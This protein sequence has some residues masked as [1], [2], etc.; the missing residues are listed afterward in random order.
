MK[1]LLA[2]ILAVAMMLSLTACGGPA[3]DPA[4]ESISEPE[5]A[6]EPAPEPAPEPVSEPEPEAEPVIGTVT[7]VSASM[8]MLQLEDGTELVLNIKG[9]EGLEV[10]VGDTVIAEHLDTAA[11]SVKVIV[12]D[13]DLAPEPVT[14]EPAQTAPEAASQAP[15]IKADRTYT[16]VVTGFSQ[17]TDSTVFTLEDGS[18]L[19]FANAESI[20]QGLNGRKFQIGDKVIFGETGT[21]FRAQVTSITLTNAGSGSTSDN[22]SSGGSSKAD[23]PPANAGDVYEAIDLINAEREKVGLEKLGIDS[24][25]MEMAAVRAE[26]LVTKYEHTRPDGRGYISIL[27]DFGWDSKKYYSAENINRSAA[28]AATTV[29]SWMNSAGHKA[30]ILNENVTR[31]GVGYCYGSSSERKNHWVMLVTS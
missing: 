22:T 21:G 25:L 13:A 12:P 17:L 4:P 14:P 3:A 8:M 29:S 11:S 1:K 2:A 24:E 9:I 15:A 31:I 7:E 16:G 20:A 23:E 30:N 19:M 28:T 18:E 10:K 26:E 27:D 6:A 5:S